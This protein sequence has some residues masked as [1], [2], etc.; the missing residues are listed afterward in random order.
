MKAPRIA[1]AVLLLLAVSAH[2]HA[3]CSN[4]LLHGTYAFSGQGFIPITSDISPALFLPQAVAGVITLNGKGSVTSGS[5]TLNTTDPNGG[6][7]RG[8]FIGTYVVD[9]NCQG[10]LE[11][12]LST[13]GELHFDLIVLSPAEFTVISTDVGGSAIYSAKK[14]VVPKQH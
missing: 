11:T 12:S 6:P 2:L 7:D 4:A 10:T 9:T 1:A 13:G 14:I 5:F 8:T 3:A